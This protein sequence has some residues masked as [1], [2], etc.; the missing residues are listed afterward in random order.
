MIEE[1]EEEEA[2][3]VFNYFAFLCVSLYTFLY[4]ATNSTSILNF[5]PISSQ[6]KICCGN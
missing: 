3:V 5:K 1:E 6:L 4:G 2:E